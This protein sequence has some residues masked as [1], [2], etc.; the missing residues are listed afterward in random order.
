MLFRSTG[1][2]HEVD[3]TIADFVSDLR[4]PT[5]S[6]A[7]ELTTPDSHELL[8]SLRQ[9]NQQLVRLTKQQIQRLQENLNWM[10]KHLQQ[11]HPKRRLR[12]RAQ[13]IDL[14]E[15]GLIRLQTKLFNDMKI[16]LQN[17]QTELFHLNPLHSIRE[18]K[19]QL[20]LHS[21]FLNNHATQSLNQQQQTIAA[22]AAKLD[23]LSPLATL[24][25]GFAIATCGKDNH[26]L[27]NAKEISV[28]DKILVKLRD[29]SLDCIVEKVIA[30]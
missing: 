4:A 27:Q 7:A 13:Q 24:K 29:G 22:L 8:N 15:M 5:P 25:R 3:F 11:Q 18:I 12:E 16:K 21:Q 10:F 30:T 2:G 9:N 23:A 28:G 6:A 19:H 17:L 14:L 1:V 20:N 26:I